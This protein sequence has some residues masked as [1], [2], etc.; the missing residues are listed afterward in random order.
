MRRLAALALAMI[1]CTAMA[2]GQG[3]TPS[4]ATATPIPGNPP[5]APS[6]AAVEPGADLAQVRIDQIVGGGKSDPAWYATSMLAAVSTAQIDAI[7]VQLKNALGAYRGVSRT[8]TGVYLARFEK[9]TDEVDIHLDE[10][11]KIDGLL[12]KPPTPANVDLDAT[13]AT[14]GAIPNI[15]YVLLEGATQR[16]GVDADRPLAVGSTFK[17]AVL[18]ALQDEIAAHK[19]R[20]SDVIQLDPARRSLPSGVLQTWPAEAP[21]TLATLAIEMISISDN[22]AADTLHALVAGPDLDR[23]AARNHPFLST[24]ALFVM[25]SD[26]GADLLRRWHD[27]HD[28]AAR[29][30]IVREAEHRPLPA[31]TD[32]PTT[33]RALDVEW[34]YSVRELCSMMAHVAALPLMSVNPGLAQRTA[35]RRVSF[36]GGAEPGVLNLTTSVVTKHGTT[37]CLSATVND[38]AASVSETSVETPYTVVLSALANR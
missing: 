14:L 37:Y 18:S 16:A 20:W 19:H 35:F 29:A 24:R 13:L 33:P 6:P 11:G 7:V 22:T 30:T 1:G 34:I 31:L 21:V 3:A 15:S 10:R 36:K 5:A 25:K 9:G 8:A 27:A 38:P 26:G 2:W 32:Y 4:A 17:L 12:F 23:Y 28:D